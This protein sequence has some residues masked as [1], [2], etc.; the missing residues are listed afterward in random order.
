MLS[1]PQ[2][3]AVQ[4]WTSVLTAAAAGAL[5]VAAATL[6]VRVF[7]LRQGEQARSEFENAAGDGS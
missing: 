5:L 2:W 4:R 3:K 6:I 1:Y 7:K